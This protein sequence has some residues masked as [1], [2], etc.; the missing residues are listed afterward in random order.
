MTA[1][2][3]GWY[4]DQA[5]PQLL[6]WWDGTAW[7]QHTQP[8]PQQPQPAQ[9]PPQQ[10]VQPQ[11][12]PV[13]QQQPAYQQ[14]QQGYPQ[15]QGYQQQQAYPQQQQPQQ[16]YQQGYQQAGAAG[17]AG[18]QPQQGMQHGAAGMGGGQVGMGPLYTATE[19]LIAQKAKVFGVS[20]KAGAYEIFDANQ[21][22]VGMFRE[23]ETLAGKALDKLNPLADFKT[24]NFELTDPGGT[25][26]L[27]IDQPQ[28]FKAT[29]KPKFEVT[30]GAGYPVGII[31]NPKVMSTAFV[32]LVNGHEVGG[33][34]REGGGFSARFPVRDAQGRQIAEF[35]KRSAGKKS[36][37]EVFTQDDSYVL[38]RP[39]PI[40]EPLGS[41]VLISACA[42][43]AAFYEND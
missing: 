39:Q 16:P 10:Y 17:F 2:S 24:K 18:Q 33:F 29:L 37:K 42:L 40:P 6:R 1:P 30:T 13:Y 41:L 8:N 22:Q 14:P 36:F 19:L 38:L 28:S 15:Q 43:D 12:Q 3:P 20:S 4:A 21:Q 32:F 23:P 31:S 9:A 35:V 27:K 7:T 11:Q 34:V 25:V 5:S 26:L